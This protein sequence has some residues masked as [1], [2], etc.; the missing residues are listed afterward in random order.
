MGVDFCN[1]RVHLTR[2]ETQHQNWEPVSPLFEKVHHLLEVVNAVFPLHVHQDAVR[3]RLH[4]D[5]QEGVDTGVVQDLG[6]FLIP[7]RGWGGRGLRSKRVMKIIIFYSSTYL[8]S[9]HSYFHGHKSKWTDWIGFL[10]KG[11]QLCDGKATGGGSLT[12]LSGPAHFS[13]KFLPAEEQQQLAGLLLDATFLF[14]CH[15]SGNE[16]TGT[17]SFTLKPSC[18]CF[19]QSQAVK[20]APGRELSWPASQAAT[21]ADAGQWYALQGK[22]NEWKRGKKYSW[23]RWHFCLSA[24]VSTREEWGE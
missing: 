24:Q 22:K 19:I 5:M 7:W 2:S 9:E 16:K 15:L 4:R 6:H 10:M 8:K 3:G 14:P 20:V 21:T 23:F 12:A 18:I 11:A 1:N 17:N 13:L